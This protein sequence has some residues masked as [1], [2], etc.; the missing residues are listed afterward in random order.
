MTVS[1]YR[2]TALGKLG[3]VLF[4]APTPIAGF[5]SLPASPPNAGRMLYEQALRDVGGTVEMALPSPII[6]ILLATATLIGAVL[7]MVGR[8]IVTED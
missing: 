4:V 2:L 8:E 3:A 1:R 7:T 5:Y 6:L